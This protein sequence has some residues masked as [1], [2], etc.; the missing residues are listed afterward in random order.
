MTTVALPGWISLGATLADGSGIAVV[1][2]PDSS[3]ERTPTQVGVLRLPELRLELRDA[4][5]PLGE[6]PH[7]AYFRLEPGV[8]PRQADQQLVHVDVV[9]VVRVDFAAGFRQEVVFETG[10]E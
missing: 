6:T 5:P 2:P 8:E 1:A 7:N 3:H 4:P 10:S 9:A